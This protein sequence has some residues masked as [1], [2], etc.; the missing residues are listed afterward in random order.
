[1]KNPIKLLLTGIAPKFD[2]A[3]QAGDV[4]KTQDIWIETGARAYELGFKMFLLTHELAMNGGDLDAIDH[5]D[6]IER[7]SKAFAIHRELFGDKN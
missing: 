7:A 3:L 2:A 6:I 1:M 5:D 4:D